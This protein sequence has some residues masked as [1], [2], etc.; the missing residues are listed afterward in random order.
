MYLSRLIR[1]T[2]SSSS[3]VSV[4]LLEYRAS[5][6]LGSS[7]SSPTERRQSVSLAV[8]HHLLHVVYLKGVFLVL[9]FSSCTRPTYSPLPV[10]MTLAHIPT[11]TTHYYLVTLLLTCVSPASQPWCRASASWTDGC[12]AFGLNLTPTRRTSSFS[13]CVNKSRRQTFSLS[14]SVES[15]FIYQLSEGVL[16][17]SELRF[18]ANIKPLTGRCF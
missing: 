14:N 6:F 3:I 16:I 11:L 17:D 2:T 15:T 10:V 8:S 7:H 5:H 18:S 4:I 13:G 1:S 12:A 9:C